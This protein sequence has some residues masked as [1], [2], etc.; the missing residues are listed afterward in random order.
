MIIGSLV[1]RRPLNLGEMLY[2]RWIIEQFLLSKIDFSLLIRN[3][4]IG[5]TVTLT[6][7]RGHNKIHVPI[8]VA[9]TASLVYENPK[10]Y[11]NPANVNFSEYTTLNLT[12][13][14][15]PTFSTLGGDSALQ[16]STLQLGR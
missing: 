3:K 14:S 1:D 6:I 15:S 13:F 8:V 9:S 4:K 16:S 11:N 7:L 2:F 12:Q 10:R 5:D